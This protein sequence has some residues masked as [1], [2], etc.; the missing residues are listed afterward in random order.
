MTRLALA[1]NALRFSFF[2]SYFFFFFFFL[3]VTAW[4][5]NYVATCS[6]MNRLGARCFEN[7]RESRGVIHPPVEAT[8][9]PARDAS[10]ATIDEQ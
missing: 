4:A 9:Y 2:L 10:V 8:T 7:R 3:P 1:D 6:Q 5:I